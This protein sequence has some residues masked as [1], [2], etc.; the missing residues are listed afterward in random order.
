[1]YNRNT[2]IVFASPMLARDSRVEYHPPIG[3]ISTIKCK[4]EVYGQRGYIL[5]NWFIGINLDT[6]YN[7]EEIT[8]HEN[9]LL[10]KSNDPRWLEDTLSQLSYYDA[11]LLGI[12]DKLTKK[13][14][15]LLYDSIK[16]Q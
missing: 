7:G 4:T 12:L 14:K 5:S 8:F 2:K 10:K 6:K 1:M 16:N 13:E 15:S 3:W 9:C 11:Y